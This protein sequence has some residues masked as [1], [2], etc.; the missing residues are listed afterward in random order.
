[1]N[2]QVIKPATR[3]VFD[4]FFLDNS[5]QYSG[6]LTDFTLAIEHSTF[7]HVG[8][9][10]GIERTSFDASVSGINKEG[11]CSS[12]LSGIMLYVVVR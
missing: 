10:G 2:I 5:N 6:S 7:R 3:T 12:V 8:F 11:A 9:G 4:L 1:M